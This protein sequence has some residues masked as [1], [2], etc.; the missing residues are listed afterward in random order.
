MTDPSNLSKTDLL[1]LQTG[2]EKMKEKAFEDPVFFVSNFLR[3]YNPKKNPTDIP[4]KPYP[5]Q[6]RIIRQ[7]VKAIEYG[8]DIFIDKTREMGVSYM[9]LAVFLWCWLSRPGFTALVGSRTE[10]QVD[11]RKGGTIGSDDASLFA[12]LGY[13]IERLPA[14]MLPVGWN[15]RM[16]FPYLKL[17]NPENGSAI[18]GESSTANFSR[19]GRY[20]AVLLDEFAFFEEAYGAWGATRDASRCRIVVTTPGIKPG[21]AKRL[22]F[23]LDGEKIKVIEVPYHLHPEKNA[24]WLAKEKE[25]RSEEDFNREIM[26]DWGLS[27]KGRIYPELDQA[28]YG[29]FPYIANQPLYVSGDYGLDGTVFLWWQQNPLNGK[30]RMIDSFLHEEEPIE[31]YFPLFGKPI[32]SMFH[33]E[34]DHLKAFEEISKLPKATHFGDPSVHKRS[35]NAEKKSDFDKLAEIGIYVY[36]YTK[37]NSIDYRV[38]TTKV[39]LKHGVEV[40]ENERNYMAL[41]LWKQYRWKTWDE[42]HETTSNFRKPLHNHASH[43]GTAAEYFFVNMKNFSV[44]TPIEPKSS[45]GRFLTSRS[46]IKNAYMGRR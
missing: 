33:Y 44:E 17:I 20:S 4:F 5:Y 32:D 7:I 25:E 16:N 40:N 10:K 27:I 12:K 1:K 26:M 24:K 43:I 42:D 14:F 39:F 34:K 35:G 22:R 21:K 6:K 37:D 23:G 28:V 9:V 30:W 11:N 46:S 41:D 45:S 19:S 8:E 2:F 13:M 31:F 18:S 3:I 15:P 29:K 38:K 36:T